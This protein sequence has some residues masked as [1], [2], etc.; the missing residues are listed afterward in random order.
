MQEKFLYKKIFHNSVTAIIQYKNEML[1]NV[2]LE[3]EVLSTVKKGL[4]FTL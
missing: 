2:K 4:N 3:V 1:Y